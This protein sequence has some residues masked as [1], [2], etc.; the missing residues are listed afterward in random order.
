MRKAIYNKP[1]SALLFAWV[2]AVEKHTVQGVLQWWIQFQYVQ[3]LSANAA[4]AAGE[5]EATKIIYTN[6]V[7][8]TLV[9]KI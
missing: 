8:C 2:D 4:Q 1:S 7:A 6:I 5:G 9:G 3:E